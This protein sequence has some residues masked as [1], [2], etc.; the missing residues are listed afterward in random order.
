[1][2]MITSYQ[3]ANLCK[4][5]TVLEMMTSM[6]TYQAA[7]IRQIGKILLQYILWFKEI[8]NC[9]HIKF[10][11][12]YFAFKLMSTEHEVNSFAYNIILW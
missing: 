1:M 3:S 10:F 11:L 2:N 9:K 6:P 4:M 8:V 5:K 12:K 7:G